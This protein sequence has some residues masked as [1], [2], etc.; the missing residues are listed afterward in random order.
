MRREDSGHYSTSTDEIGKD[1]NKERLSGFGQNSFT[2][3]VN[4]SSEKTIMQE[5]QY[6][7]YGERWFMLFIFSFSCFMN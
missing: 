7:L 1:F 5:N 6:K 4:K 3:K 2:K